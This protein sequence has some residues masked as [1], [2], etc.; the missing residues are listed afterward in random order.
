MVIVRLAQGNNNIEIR[1]KLGLPNQAGDFWCGWS[2]LGDLSEEAGIY[3]K[4]PRKSG[5]IFVRMKHY[6]TCN[7]QTELQ[8]A[9][10]TV[11]AEGVALWQ[12]LSIEDQ[13]IWNRKK[14]PSGRSG[15]NRFMRAHMKGEL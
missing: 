5:Q 1:G 12:A 3:Q 2:M 7:P 8:Q 15:F 14:H 11:F 13:I 10:R 6:I 9:N 4:R